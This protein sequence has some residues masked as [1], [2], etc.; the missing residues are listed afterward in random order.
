MSIELE[1]LEASNDPNPVQIP[2]SHNENTKTESGPQ[3]S[4]FANSIQLEE[5]VVTA[6]RRCNTNYK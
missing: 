6:V 4:I 5:A 3:N 2:F 1:G